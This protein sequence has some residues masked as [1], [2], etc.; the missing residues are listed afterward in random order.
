MSDQSHPNM[1]GEIDHFLGF[2]KE[3]KISIISKNFDIHLLPRPHS[4]HWS[5]KNRK[6]FMG[7]TQYVQ[8][9]VK[10]D[11]SHPI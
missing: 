6:K 9:N 3:V 4:V 2:K 10:S 5:K 1:R 7:Y 8:K 11:Q